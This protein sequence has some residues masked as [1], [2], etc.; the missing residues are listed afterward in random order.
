VRVSNRLSDVRILA[1]H[2]R[3]VAGALGADA[4]QIDD[5]ERAAVEAVTNII[6]HGYGSSSKGPVKLTVLRRGELLQV[7]I[8]DQAPPVPTE[9]A[10]RLSGLPADGPTDL[11]TLPLDSL[12]EGGM[13]ILLITASVDRIELA[14]RRNTTRLRLITRLGNDPV[15][16]RPYQPDQLAP[17]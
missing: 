17:A 6:R 16:P 5:I 9:V 2:L 11:E 1:D 10:E 12:P 15:K 14:R 7:D 3:K 4:E 13:G 8:L